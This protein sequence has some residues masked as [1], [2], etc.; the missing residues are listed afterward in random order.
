VELDFSG[1][2]QATPSDPM[3]DRGFAGTG[4]T[5]Q[6]FDDILDA[7]TQFGD[8]TG[9]DSVDFSDFS[10]AGFA[11][12]APRS[13]IT[14]S[15]SY[16][17]TFAALGQLSRGLDPRDLK[18]Y[19]DTSFAKQNVDGIMSLRPNSLQQLNQPQVDRITE[20]LKLSGNTDA[21]KQVSSLRGDDLKNYAAGMDLKNLNLSDFDKMDTQ[22]LANIFSTLGMSEKN[23]YGISAQG[24]QTGITGVISNLLGADTNPDFRG[25]MSS[26]DI[27]EK[28]RA[29]L[30][31]A[32]GSGQLNP[33]ANPRNPM[34]F[35]SVSG[36]ANQFGRD[37]SAGATQIKDGLLGLA[38]NVMNFFNKDGKAQA[39]K[40][41][42]DI[43]T[44]ENKL[45]GPPQFNEFS[46][47][48][49]RT[50]T[51]DGLGVES[52]LGELDFPGS[53]NDID[54]NKTVVAGTNLSPGQ[55]SRSRDP[56]TESSF[57]GK[58]NATINMEKLPL[59]VNLTQEPSKFMDRG[60]SLATNQEGIATTSVNQNFP[61]PRQ[62]PDLLRDQ[63]KYAGYGKPSGEGIVS[64]PEASG[65]DN[66]VI[67]AGS[68]NGTPLS[69]SILQALNEQGFNLD[70]NEEALIDAPGQRPFDGTDE[71]SVRTSDNGLTFANSFNRP[72]DTR[73]NTIQPPSGPALTEAQLRA[74]EFDG[75]TLNPITG[76]AI[77][78]ERG[79]VQKLKIEDLSK[80]L[81]GLV[82]LNTDLDYG[83]TISVQD[84]INMSPRGVK[85]SNTALIKEIQDLIDEGRKDLDRRLSDGESSTQGL[86]SLY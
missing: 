80:E 45:Q 6:Q 32:T 21:Y 23:P 85:E 62:I 54:F 74:A 47:V 1:Y 28:A 46:R 66:N 69:N 3:D 24:T 39:G 2:T 49:V 11:G 83:D 43:V 82:S 55:Y 4:S 53:K 18:D 57:M 65:L 17:P 64:L 59:G 81:Q 44:E 16:D 78:D 13:N 52:V 36:I 77:Y 67:S 25:S 41:I 42:D 63:I 26:K 19:Q 29:G 10:S 27:A 68:Q 56:M 38:D 60:N 79:P 15:S 70:I 5:T 9:G 30:G 58:K 84:L 61:D 35:G 34:E 33:N 31:F 75:F 51:R 71:I 22:S 73:L 20:A 37:A 86:P 76:Q 8:T 14:N 72:F 12:G 48:P 50:T 7:S 40:T